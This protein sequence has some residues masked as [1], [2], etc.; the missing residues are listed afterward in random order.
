MIDLSTT[1][2]ETD[3]RHALIVKPLDIRVNEIARRD[4]KSCIL[5]D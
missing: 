5:A 3:N 2:G 4:R 1:L